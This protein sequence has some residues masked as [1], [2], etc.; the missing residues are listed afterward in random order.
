MVENISVE[1]FH[2]EANFVVLRVPGRKYPGVLIQGDTLGGLVSDLHE[3]LKNLEKD[4]AEA[5]DCLEGLYAEL[6]SKLDD[7][8]RICRDSGIR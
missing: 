6:K 1:V 2:E 3:A 4:P 7:Y 5:R 8:A